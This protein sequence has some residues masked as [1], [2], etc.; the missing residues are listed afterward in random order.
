[1][2]SCGISQ[3]F[4]VIKN[5]SI[6][7]FISLIFSGCFHNEKVVVLKPRGIEYCNTNHCIDDSDFRYHYNDFDKY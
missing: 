3:R 7:L 4:Q 2:L 6:L 1:M 5:T